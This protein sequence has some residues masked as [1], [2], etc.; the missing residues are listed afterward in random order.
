MYQTRITNKL[1]LIHENKIIS[2]HH[3]GCYH[4]DFSL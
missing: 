1:Q 3:Y 4:I 2:I